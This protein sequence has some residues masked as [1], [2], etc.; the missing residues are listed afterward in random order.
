MNRT[1]PDSAYF[2]SRR[3]SELEQIHN[4]KRIELIF[5][6]PVPRFVGMRIYQ[7]IRKEYGPF[8][9]GDTYVFEGEPFAEVLLQRNVAVINTPRTQPLTSPAQRTHFTSPPTAHKTIAHSASASRSSGRECQSN[10]LRWLK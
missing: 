9:P 2:D 3:S 1:Y 10:I 8:E 6:K 7:G 5:T 4:P